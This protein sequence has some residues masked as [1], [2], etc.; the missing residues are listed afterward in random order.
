MKMNIREVRR[1]DRALL[2]GE[3][4]LLLRRGQGSPSAVAA[5][6]QHLQV[7]AAAVLRSV[8][9]GGEPQGLR[10]LLEDA[11]SGGVCAAAMTASMAQCDKTSRLELVTAT[12]AV[13]DAAHAMIRAAGAA[14]ARKRRAVLVEDVVEEER[15]EESAPEEDHV[16]GFL[17]PAFGT[18]LLQLCRA[19]SGTRLDF[20]MADCLLS[21]SL[22]SCQCRLS[23]GAEVLR[24]VTAWYAGVEGASLLCTGLR[25]AANWLHRPEAWAELVSFVDRGNARM[26]KEA[27]V[28]A[29]ELTARLETAKSSFG[30]ERALV[31]L[32]LLLGRLGPKRR[33]KCGPRTLRTSLLENLTQFASLVVSLVMEVTE[34]EAVRS[35]V[36]EQLLESLLLAGADG[37]ELHELHLLFEHSVT[38]AAAE[39][40]ARQ[41]KT[42]AAVRAY[43]VTRDANCVVVLDLAEGSP[44]IAAGAVDERVWRQWMNLEASVW[45]RI[46]S[47]DALDWEKGSLVLVEQ[48]MAHPSETR[49]VKVASVMAKRLSQVAPAVLM[50][51][52]DIMTTQKRLSAALLE[53]ASSADAV[54]ELLFLRLAPLLLLRV[55]SLAAME[56][57]VTAG[58][59]ELLLDRMC[60]LYEFDQVRRLAAEAMSKVRVDVSMPLTAAA[61]DAAIARSD[62]EEGAVALK[63]LLY[64]WCGVAVSREQVPVYQLL[65]RALAAGQVGEELCFVLLKKHTAAVMTIAHPLS[66]AVLGVLGRFFQRLKD[67]CADV[68]DAVMG[69]LLSVKPASAIS[70][71]LLLHAIMENP[72]AASRHVARLLQVALELTVP[73]RPHED[74]YR[75]LALLGAL[76]TVDACIGDV[77]SVAAVTEVLSRYSQTSQVPQ[78]RDAAT[79]ILSTINA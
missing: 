78:L 77:R 12:K 73:E 5:V 40:V 69:P 4:V 34:G 2:A 48:L 16:F 17:W 42:V 47:V 53:D 27:K 31:L 60:S 45:D 23:A 59:A 6:A 50:R 56:Q 10:A 28:I 46:V 36:E 13:L 79:K 51:L 71:S 32:C 7:D 38:S 30:K 72:S 20:A 76:L 24:C 74:Q 41:L 61:F 21:L 15:G 68:A 66:A 22:L 39:K 55:L 3:A 58:F 64:C 75:G 25:R 14:H 1:E 33:R 62:S 19:G 37:Q 52:Q 49:L 67:N 9:A 44:E 8:C 70:A 63:T 18:E 26:E 65:P 29:K 11:R 54:K 43:R 57:H 35:I